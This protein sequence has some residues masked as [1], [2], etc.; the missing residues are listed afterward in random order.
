MNRHIETVQSCGLS[1]SKMGHRFDQMHSQPRPPAGSAPLQFLQDIHGESTIMR[2]GLDQM[3]RILRTQCRHAIQSLRDGNSEKLAV[4]R[5]NAD[6]REK[7]PLFSDLSSGFRVVAIDRMIKRQ[8]HPIVKTH[9]SN[10]LD[11][12]L[13]QTKQGI[14][15][16]QPTTIF[17]IHKAL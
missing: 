9:R 16:L 1:G 17:A 7:I 5:P 14:R 15:R 13:N 8:T 12:M 3:E 6:A 11:C 10:G 4:D 2:P